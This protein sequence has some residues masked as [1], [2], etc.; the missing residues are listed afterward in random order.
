MFSPCR[1]SLVV[2][3]MAA[4][5]AI[6]AWAQSFTASVRGTVTDESNALIA[7]AKIV[8][9]DAERG[10]VFNAN[11]DDAGRFVVTALPPGSYIMTV[12]AAGFKKFSSGRFTLSVQEQATVNA[13]L[14]IGD[15]ATTI[16]VE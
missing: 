1:R 6:T 5:A 4:L 8:V 13:K 12:E 2:C 11:A 7:A 16:E 14:Q 15:V 9:T 10:T 3:S